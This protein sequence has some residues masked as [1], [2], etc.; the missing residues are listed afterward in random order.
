MLKLYNKIFRRHKNID[1]LQR[2][3]KKFS[4]GNENTTIRIVLIGYEPR[5]FPRKK[6]DKFK[7]KLF[8]FI[9]TEQIHREIKITD[10]LDL[11][12]KEYK[13]KDI[14]SCL[15]KYP[16]N[17]IIIAIVNQIVECG[18]YGGCI[19]ENERLFYLSLYGT[20]E[21]LRENHVSLYNFIILAAYRNLFR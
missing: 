17:E 10:S 19:D 9:I 3:V 18:N 16:H 7:S 6:L 5:G 12:L 14:E 1:I 11:T 21:I 4:A 13:R 8:K 2:V 20:R 15:S